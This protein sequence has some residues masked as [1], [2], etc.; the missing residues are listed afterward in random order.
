VKAILKNRELDSI[1]EIEEA[2]T[3]IWDGLSFDAVQT[4]FPS[5]MQRLAGVI[6]NEGEHIRE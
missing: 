1:D 6:G 2:N 4:V 3:E 5:R